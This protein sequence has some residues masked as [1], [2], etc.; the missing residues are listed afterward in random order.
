MTKKSISKAAAAARKATGQEESSDASN[1]DVFQRL[2]TID[3]SFRSSRGNRFDAEMAKGVSAADFLLAQMRDSDPLVRLDA[4]EA[5]GHVGGSGVVKA[6]RSHLR[7][8]D[9]DV[10]TAV[11]VAL[12]RAGDQQLFPEV[13]KSLR[14]DDPKVVIGAA[15]ALGHL[16]DR[17]VVPNLVEAFKTDEIEVGAAVAWALGRCGDPSALPWL[18]TA[19][20]QG[21][22]VANACEAL[23]RIGDPRAQPALLKALA[24]AAD[25]VRAYAARALGL[26]KH[27]GSGPK[28]QLGLMAEN[29]A[30]PVLKKLL[31]DQSRK[32]RLC[33]AISLYELGEQLGGRR[34]VQDLR[35]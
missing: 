5:L 1:V 7:D 17:R 35:D 27:G 11:A 14:H 22:A 24:N 12:I 33:A 3:P 23:G 8:A 15:V 20:E 29:K 34:L 9:G 4:A 19:V 28:G 21:F 13:V 18:I 32:V 25:D 26:L 10:R 16:A 31:K 2:E 6:L 30:V